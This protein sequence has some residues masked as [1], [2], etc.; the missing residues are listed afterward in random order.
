VGINYYS[1]FYIKRAAPT[2][3]NVQEVPVAGRDDVV[4]FKPPDMPTTP[5]VGLSSP[6]ASMTF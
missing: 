1:P 4:M 3:A 5:M 6:R 2:D